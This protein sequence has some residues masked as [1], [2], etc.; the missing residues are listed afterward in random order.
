MKKG[1]EVPLGPGARDQ[2]EALIGEAE[3]QQ[4]HVW[5][6][7]VVLLSAYGVRTMT[8]PRQTGKGKPTI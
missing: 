3:S 8:I 6:A 1:I 5:R 2:L 4:K 7:R